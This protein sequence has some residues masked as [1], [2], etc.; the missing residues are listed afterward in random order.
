MSLIKKI[1]QT[2]PYQLKQMAKWACATVPAHVRLGREF[3]RLSA[4]LDETQWWST[5]K[6]EE[7]QS[8]RL[9]LLIR[10]V[11]KNVPYYTRLFQEHGISPSDINTIYDLPKIPILT[12][13]VLRNK[14]RDLISTNFDEKDL[15]YLST[16]GTTGQP[17]GFYSEKKLEYADGD[18]FW[19]RRLRWGGC[20]PKNRRAA[21]TAWTIQPKPN[22]MRRIFSYNPVR[23]LLIL[24]TYD[25][26]RENF[27]QYAF[28]LRKYQPEFILCFPSA[29]E[30]MVKY[31]TDAGIARPVSPRAIFT[32]S[33]VIYPWQKELIENYFGCL[34]YDWYGMEERVVCA[35]QCGSH[36]GYH[37]F[38]EFSIVEFVKKQKQVVGKDG[39]I[40]ATRLDN[41]AMPLIRYQTGDIGRKLEEKCACGR[42]LPLMRLIGGR[43]RSFAVTAEGGLISVTIVDIPKATKNIEQFQFVQKQKGELTLRIVKKPNFSNNDIKLIYENLQSKFGDMFKIDIEFVMNIP[44]TARGKF[45]LLMQ[46]LK[47]DEL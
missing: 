40:I 2:S 7:Y 22:G 42:G 28:A 11:Y 21:L 4:W 36:S 30:I 20:N 46:H 5:E 27:G 6:L 33:E 29:L 43:D 18:P 25:L 9:R 32:Q 19:W 23:R 12:K 31:F 38:S 10:H 34:I 3:F 41:Y 26:S 44:R 24:S 16:S 17:V 37:I 8:E 14:L 13:E 35:S 47:V 15:V 1:Y 45:P 39:E